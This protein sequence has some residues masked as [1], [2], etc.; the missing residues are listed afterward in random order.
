VDPPLDGGG[1]VIHLRAGLLASCDEET[2]V[3]GVPRMVRALGVGTELAE[4]V[5][6]SV[7]EKAA[8][9]AGATPSIAL[10]ARLPG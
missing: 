9:K 8:T 10:A 6:R 7:P 4:G 1:F 5:R 2:Q 3:H